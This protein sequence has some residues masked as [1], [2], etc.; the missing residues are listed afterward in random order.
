MSRS[1][2]NGGKCSMRRLVSTSIVVMAAA[3][4]V[5]VVAAP[6]VRAQGVTMNVVDVAGNLA[7]TQEA[8]ELYAKRNPGKVAKLVFTKAPAPELPGKLKAM[9]AAGRA[10]IDLV[11]TGVGF[12]GNAVE[13]GLLVRILPD[14]A[15][16]F[17]QRVGVGEARGWDVPQARLIQFDQRDLAV[18]RPGDALDARR[19]GRGVGVVV[20]PQAA[21]GV[22]QLVRQLQMP[23]AQ[24][25]GNSGQMGG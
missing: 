19:E 4:L 25:F 2:L 15:A 16:K 7:L 20:Q 8:F 23:D 3:T 24:R 1:G 17:T 12:L 9:Q 10:D 21:K 5:G 22:A 13:Q 6:Q 18:L 14:H 11:L